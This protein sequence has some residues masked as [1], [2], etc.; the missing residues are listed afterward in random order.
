MTE[1]VV[2]HDKVIVTVAGTIQGPPGQPGPPG[3]PGPQ[4]PQGHGGF[5]SADPGNAITTGT[6]GGLYCNAAAVGVQSILVSDA[7]GLVQVGA[8]GG[9]SPVKYQRIDG[10]FSQIVRSD[11]IWLNWHPT[12]AGVTTQVIGGQYMVRIPKFYFR[13]GVVPSGAYAGKAYW[14]ISPTPKSGFSVHP[15]FIGAGGVELDQIWVGK[16]QASYDGV[17]KAQSVP[18]ALPMASMDFPTARDRAYARNTGLV[19]GFRLWSIYDLSA[20]QMLATIEIGGLDMQPLIGMGRV[21]APSAA[22][23]DAD[24]VAHATWRGIVGLWGNIWQMVDGIKTLNG[25]W[26]RWQYNVPGSATAG[27]FSTGYVDTNQTVAIGGYFLNTFNTDL[28]SSGIIAASTISNAASDDSTGDN[29][30]SYSD[31]FD[32]TWHHGGEFSNGTAA[33]LFYSNVVNVPSFVGDRVG[34]RIAKV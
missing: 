23:V 3:P 10:N 22:N 5:P 24:D 6:D 29:W 32:R 13:A 31:N 1:N 25:H 14:M 17:S 27:D 16:Y 26:H 21:Y 11:N 12:Y 2:V 18:G 8:G 34:T 20:I 7:V 4:G 9:G 30:Y 15:A 19:S 28:L 33:G